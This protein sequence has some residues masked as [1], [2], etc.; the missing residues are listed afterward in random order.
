MVEVQAQQ[1][2]TEENL[3]DEEAILKL[4]AAM[5]D[6]TPTQEEKQ[7][8]HTFLL[9]VV[10][11]EEPSKIIKLGNLRDDKEMNELG[12]PVWTARGALDM[13]RISDKIMDNTFF[14][15][16]FENQMVHTL[17]SSLSREGFIIRAAVTNT[18][19]V[20]DATKRK[21]YNSGMFGNKKV[22]EES[23]GD[24]LTSK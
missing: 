9:N 16:Y 3:S 10:Q 20:V 15:E 8:V 6:N 22:L 4:A 21:K 1:V 13:V 19:Q 7:N 14:K 23:G 5:K 11:A 17:S 24:T 18:K 2:E 12:A